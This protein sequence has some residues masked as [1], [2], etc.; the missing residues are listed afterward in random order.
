MQFFGSTDAR[1]KEENLVTSKNP[2][3]GPGCY[4]NLYAKSFKD[5]KRANTANFVGGGRKDL[6]KQND[7]PAPGNYETKGSFQMKNW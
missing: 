4:Q 3:L 7:N 5:A 6:T 1:I 2:N